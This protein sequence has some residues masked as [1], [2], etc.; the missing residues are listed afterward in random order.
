[1]VCLAVLAAVGGSSQ[2][3]ALSVSGGNPSSSLFCSRLANRAEAAQ[4][5]FTSLNSKVSSAWQSQDTRL[6]NLAGDVDD[7]V[8]AA[9]D[10]IDDQRK[11]NFAKL[12]DKATTD[13]QKQ[14]VSTYETAILS[15]V[16]TRRAIVD[17]ARDTFRVAVADAIKSRRTNLSNQVHGLQDAISVAYSTA[18]T[19]CSGG[20]DPSTVRSTLIDSLKSSRQ[21]YA[22][23]R[24]DDSNIRTVIAGIA[25]SRNITIKSANQDFLTSVKKAVET[26][27]A[28]FG[29]EANKLQA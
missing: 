20:V 6:K 29:D 21:T 3:T 4:N 25:K 28:A 9:R 13:G 15:A 16:D 18:Q 14:A 24:K 19:S 10:R 23:L 27:K 17:A 2:A 12:E 11:L 5:R 22:E 1:M 26:L 7:E 8:K